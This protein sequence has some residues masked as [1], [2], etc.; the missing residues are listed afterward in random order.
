M[1]P[2]GGFLHIEFP[3]DVEFDSVVA[4][5]TASCDPGVTSCRL[6]D[7]NPKMIIIKTIVE[8]GKEQ[9][10]VHEIGGVKNSRTFEPSGSFKI[11]SYDQDGFM[12]DTGYNKNVQ[13]SI[14]GKIT[15]EPIGRQNTT[16]GAINTYV[17]ELTTTVPMLNSDVLKFSFPAGIELNADG[18]TTTCTPANAADKIICG[19]SGNDVQITFV[20]LAT[21]DPAD[22]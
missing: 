13:T 20:T 1:V 3:S 18:Q 16:N 21:R 8:V 9:P 12:I 19:I 14:A 5:S 10:V 22:P 4:L 6:D 11:T 17:F 2:Q 15:F 7:A